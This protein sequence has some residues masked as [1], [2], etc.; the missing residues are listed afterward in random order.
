MNGV[1]A[2]RTGKGV[3][4]IVLGARDVDD[5]AGKLRD[6]GEMALLLGRPRQRGADQGECKGLMV[7]EK[8]EFMGFQEKTEMTDKGVG[9]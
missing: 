6:I 8:S 2:G 7:C 3:S 9:K 4:N 5:I 1:R